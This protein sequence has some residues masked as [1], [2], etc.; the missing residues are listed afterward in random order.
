MP[1]QEPRLTV[2]GGF[3]LHKMPKPYRNQ[4]RAIVAAESATAARRYAQAAG[5]RL[6]YSA[7]RDFWSETG[8]TVEVTVATAAPRVLL[9]Q[10]ND[11]V[12]ITGLHGTWLP[13]T[14]SWPTTS[15]FSPASPCSSCNTSIE[16]CD[17][18]VLGEGRP[19]CST[20]RYT[21]T[22]NDIDPEAR[23]ARLAKTS[24]ALKRGENASA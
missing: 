23:A 3:A 4:V 20:C 2:F 5:Y 7:M 21:D 10:P 12:P 6:T 14:W 18:L 15:P 8:N 9:Y 17:R 24:A 13:W 16:R 1:R 11:V 22:H 19:C